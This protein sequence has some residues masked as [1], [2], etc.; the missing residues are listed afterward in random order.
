MLENAEP[1]NARAQ[2][3]FVRALTCTLG[4]RDMETFTPA[5]IVVIVNPFPT[6]SRFAMLRR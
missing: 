2:T 1:E 3:D 4:N 6:R 5:M